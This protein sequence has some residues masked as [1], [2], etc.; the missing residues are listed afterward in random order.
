MLEPI[1]FN[2]ANLFI[3]ILKPIYAGNQSNVIWEN[4]YMSGFET[5]LFAD[6]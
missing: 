2:A 3:L 6:A 4:R 1:Y 5:Y